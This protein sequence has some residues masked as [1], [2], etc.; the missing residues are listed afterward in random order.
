MNEHKKNYYISY[1]LLLITS[2]VALM[3]VVGGIT[4]LTDSG[5]S[6]TKW[7]LFTGVIPPLSLDNWEEVFLLYQKIPEFKLE[8]ASMTLDEFK[9]IFFWEY[10][11]RLLGRIIGLFYFLPL[12]YFTYMRVIKKNDLWSFYIIFFLIC[13]QGVVGWY[14]VKSG[15]SE[16]T[17]VSHYRLSL[18]LTI[19]FI[20][21]ILL[22]LKYLKFN[23]KKYL[24]NKIT[25][26]LFLPLIF[27]YII[28]LQISIGALVSGLNAG[29]IYTTWPLMN[30]NYFPDDVLFKNIFTL[31]LFETPS[32]VQFVHRNIAYFIFV[33]FLYIFY[34]V[35]KNENFVYLRKTILLIFLSLIFQIILGIFTIIS[36]AEILLASLHQIGSIILITTSTVLVFKNS[37]N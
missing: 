5:L 6:I 9:I 3:I 21:F 28:L 22:L 20:I 37:K 23:N 11:H 34:V 30:E 25:L 10:I 17:D 16:R 26:P 24:I 14:M 15:L 31:N 27:T 35:F 19:A 32:L 29:Q 2:L 33:I 13:I 36:G 1:W 7:D 12:L 8:N 18:H 4:R